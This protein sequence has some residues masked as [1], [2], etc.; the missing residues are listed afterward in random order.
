MSNTLSPAEA[1]E[2]LDL[3]DELLHSRTGGPGVQAPA[4]C[5]VA[6]NQTESWSLIHRLSIQ[7]AERL[8]WTIDAEVRAQA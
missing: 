7:V 1:K 4:E 3:A 2:L 8:R 5:C 6:V